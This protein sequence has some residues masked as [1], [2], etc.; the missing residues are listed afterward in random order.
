MASLFTNSS[1]QTALQTLTAASK[2]LS[3]TQ[4]RVSTGYRIN[5]AEDNAA[6]WSIATTLRSDVGA[7]GAVKDALGLGG[8]TID[9]VYTGINDTKDLLDQVKSKL[10]AASQTGVPRAQVQAE[11]TQL[12]NRLKDT[13]KSTVIN[14]ES[15]LTQNS[16]ANGYNSTKSVVGSFT[17]AAGAVT[18]ENIDIDIGK[19]K[20]Y[21]TSDSA[22]TTVTT[23]LDNSGAGA[24]MTYS[25]ALGAI[26]SVTAATD[27]AWNAS[28]LD[29][30]T[31]DAASAAK[32]G[33]PAAARISG[34]IATGTAVQTA[35]AAVHTVTAG[36]L[37]AALAVFAADY[38][39]GGAAFVASLTTKQKTD[40]LA[41]VNK[42]GT[43]Y[44][45]ELESIADAA[46][47][48]DTGTTAEASSADAAKVAA[49]AYDAAVATA[50][51]KVLSTSAR[52]AFVAKTG[53]DARVAYEATATVST[54]NQKLGIFDKVRTVVSSKDGTEAKAVRVSDID[55]SKLTDT[56]FDKGVLSAY[57]S[58]VD[59]ALQELTLSASILGAAKSR[60]NGNQTFVQNLIDANKRGI[61]QLVDA[62]L[63]EESSKLKALQVQEQLAVQA[64]GIANNSTQ[65][66]LSLF[67]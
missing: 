23:A 12:Q 8:A 50:F 54:D 10:V 11:V 2:S 39:N 53:K 40:L 67:R 34:A 65:N 31:G 60:V 44:K 51:G 27:S 18:I 61:G 42:A 32:V 33:A 37:D 1:A 63:N 9:T 15:W 22:Q 26:K 35:S 5:T 36:E 45:T 17:R 19:T 7:L 3:A 4:N 6:Y 48:G 14:S 30:A 25:T 43:E 29:A 38:T 28:A 24:L 58:A 56:D 16:S 49:T 64:L 59:D 41:E 20:L 57:I 55:I 46:T 62:D 21:E 66:I 52:D 13:S 47:G